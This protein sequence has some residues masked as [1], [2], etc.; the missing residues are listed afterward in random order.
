MKRFVPVVT[1][2]DTATADDILSLDISQLFNAQSGSPVSHFSWWGSVYAAFR[3][4][5]RFVITDT[6]NGGQVLFTSDSRMSL[7]EYKQLLGFDSKIQ[8][9]TGPWI[10]R[11]H[12]TQTV[13]L[14]TPWISTNRYLLLP[15]LAA[16]T[17]DIFGA[18]HQAGALHIA[19]LYVASQLPLNLAAAFSDNASFALPVCVPRV[20]VSTS[21]F[22]DDYPDAF[23]TF[24]IGEYLQVY[25]DDTKLPFAWV[26]A[27]LLTA[28][29]SEPVSPFDSHDNPIQAA[30]FVIPSRF[31]TAQMLKDLGFAAHENDDINY[32]ADLIS[33]CYSDLTDVLCVPAVTEI[34]YDAKATSINEQAGV[35]FVL[36]GGLQEVNDGKDDFNVGDVAIN[37]VPNWTTGFLADLWGIVSPTLA[38]PTAENAKRQHDLLTTFDVDGTTYGVLDGVSTPKLAL[39]AV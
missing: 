8:T 11:N 27:E 13:T 31:F 1:L 9:V 33:T 7:S 35:P 19:R 17:T 2:P 15:K 28:I 24:T 14:Q 22:G 30:S 32:V 37:V 38:V 36:S 3:G 12:V 16:H 23:G 25:H 20:R 21:N 39:R 26:Q 6:T 18:N 34:S 4:E 10:Y 5:F 29:S